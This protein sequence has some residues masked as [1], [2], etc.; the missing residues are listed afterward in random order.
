MVLYCSTLILMDLLPVQESLIL[1]WRRTWQ[2]AWE[3]REVANVA[4]LIVFETTCQ[5]KEVSEEWKKPNSSP[6]L[7]NT[8]E[9]SRND[10]TICLISISVKMMEQIIMEIIFRTENHFHFM[11]MKATRSSQHGFTNGKSCLMT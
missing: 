4:W 10:K 1:S 2:D 8:E 11:E 9:D 5:L 7:K 6:T 3:L